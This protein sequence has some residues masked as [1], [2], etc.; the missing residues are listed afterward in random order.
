MGVK[1]WA[2]FYYGERVFEG[3]KKLPNGELRDNLIG[4]PPPHR[5][6]EGGAEGGDR[7]PQLSDLSFFSLPTYSSGYSFSEA[8]AKICIILYNVLY[9]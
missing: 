2:G 9:K 5:R 4:I 6:S 1:K 8:C 3:S 7:P